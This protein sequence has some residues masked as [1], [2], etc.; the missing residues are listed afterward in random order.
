MNELRFKFVTALVGGL[1]AMNIHAS[2]PGT[3]FA[4]SVDE[5]YAHWI[6]LPDEF[7]GEKEFPLIVFLHGAGERGD[8]LEKVKVHGPPKLLDDPANKSR[9]PELFASIVVTPQCPSDFWWTPHR[10]KA[11][12]DRIRDTYPVNDD[13]IYLT[14]LSMGG[15]GTF[16]TTSEYPELFAA[17]AP[18]CGGGD[19]YYFLQN[20]FAVDDED[21]VVHPALKNIIDMPASRADNLVSIPLWVFHGDADSVVPVEQSRMMVDA[22][23]ERG[24]SV[25]FTVYPGVGHDSW[26]ET[27]A[28]PELYTWLFSHTK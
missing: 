12:I 5:P 23:R 15:F 6:Y 1:L 26:T 24:G 2:E 3:Q 10:I 8:D 17:A 14:G 11:L 19:G 28:N 13:R 27:Y 22:V 4:A 18:I 7:D 16:A 9:Y 20:R 21:I 25:K